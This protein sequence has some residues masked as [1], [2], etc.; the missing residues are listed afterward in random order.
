[1]NPLL[2][3]ILVCSG[4]VGEGRVTATSVWTK[5]NKYL[6]NAIV[7]SSLLL[8]PD[9]P[10]PKEFPPSP[11]P[12][13]VTPDPRVSSCPRSEKVWALTATT[14]KVLL[15]KSCLLSWY[16]PFGEQI[17][18]F[19]WINPRNSF[20]VGRSFK[21][22]GIFNLECFNSSRNTSVKGEMKCLFFSPKT[23]CPIDN[24]GIHYILDILDSL[25]AR[26]SSEKS[27]TLII[28]GEQKRTGHLSNSMWGSLVK[29]HTPRGF[30][31][32]FLQ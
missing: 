7:I 11:P 23:K 32:G 8:Q 31:L 6:Q 20:E 30:P 25:V 27:S 19:G 17:S 26:T 21:F 24:M 4:V 29:H 1:M 22:Y 15:R 2:I 28:C 18:K 14:G 3:E 9:H 5:C 13:T 12:A 16:K 10:P